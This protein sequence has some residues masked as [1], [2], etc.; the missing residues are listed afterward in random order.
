MSNSR[1]RYPQEI[2]ERVIRL[3]AEVRE[4]YDSE[5]AAIESVA[6]RLGSVGVRDDGRTAERS[7]TSGYPA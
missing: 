1:P 3:V 4:Q 5:G 2:K 6:T 7:V